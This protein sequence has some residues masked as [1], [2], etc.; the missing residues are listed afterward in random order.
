MSR[1]AVRAVA[2]AVSAV[3]ATTVAGCSLFEPEE[4][5]PVMSEIPWEP[6]DAS[7]AICGMDRAAVE[8]AVGMAV[9]RVEGELTGQG[10]SA[11]G[12]CSI[13]PAEDNLVKGAVLWV[14]ILPLSGAEG[15]RRQAEL[16]GEVEGV[17]EPEV[18][19]EDVEGG[20]WFTDG[21][22]DAKES[23]LGGTSVVVLRDHVVALTSSWNGEG[24]DAAADMLALSQQVAAS[25]G[26]PAAD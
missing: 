13:W 25:H 2:A 23:M 8:T 19:Y 16:R 10:E 6:T 5:E 1:P 11:G 4:P 12:E 20:M 15:Q 9:D 14:S 3:L 21:S 17:V 7:E 26:L 22:A 18:R 24:R